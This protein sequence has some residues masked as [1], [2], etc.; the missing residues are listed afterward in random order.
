MEVVSSQSI[1]PN[2][3]AVPRRLVDVIASEAKQSI[4]PRKERMDCFASL[5]KTFLLPH[6]HEGRNTLTQLLPIFRRSRESDTSGDLPDRLSFHVPVQPCFEK[7]SAFR[8]TQITSITP[9]VPPHSRGVSRSSRTR[10]W[11]RWTRVVL[12]TRALTLRTVKSFGPDASTPA[13]SQRRQL[14]R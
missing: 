9:A 10:G 3:P 2:A 13:S 11:M 12:L 8:F 1:D 7:F 5:A 6:P 14:R 4:S